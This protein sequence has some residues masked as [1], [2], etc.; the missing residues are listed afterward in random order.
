MTVDPLSLAATAVCIAGLS[1]AL[2]AV[3]YHTWLARE[4]GVRVAA[5]FGRPAFAMAWSAGLFLAAI[6]WATLRRGHWW[7]VGI[8]LALAASLAWDLIRLART[9]YTHRT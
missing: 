9:W 5:A 1:T 2:A 7:E 3:S 8:C 6:G 4:R